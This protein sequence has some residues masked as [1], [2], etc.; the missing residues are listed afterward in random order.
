MNVEENNIVKIV[1]KDTIIEIINNPL[2]YFSEKS[3]Q[4]RISS[5]LIQ[6]PQISRL[7]PTAIRNRYAKYYKNLGQKPVTIDRLTSISKL[8]MEYGTNDKGAYRI[9]IAILDHEDIKKIDSFQF[10]INGRYLDPIIGIEIGTEK[11]GLNNMTK[12]HLE[13][14]A[15]KLR[16]SKTAFVVNIIRNTNL[17]RIGTKSYKDKEDRLQDF[18]NGLKEIAIFKKNIIWIGLIIYVNYNK[19]ELFNSDNT[20]TEYSPIDTNIGR[21]ISNLESRLNLY[22]I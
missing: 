13:N 19:I 18:K 7:I 10:Q 22:D 11:S 3:L 16:N 12:K 15:F 6:Y 21:I 4:L 5:K 9:D 14:D 1:L 8:Q 20:W 17:S 2:S